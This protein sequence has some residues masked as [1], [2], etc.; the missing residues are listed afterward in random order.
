MIEEMFLRYVNCSLYLNY[1]SDTEKAQMIDEFEE[2]ATRY[3]FKN[4]SETTP[5]SEIIA[6][7]RGQL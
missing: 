7:W 6:V 2:Y 5:M 4:Y 3:G 1:Y